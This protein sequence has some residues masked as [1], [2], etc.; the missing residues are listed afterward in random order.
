M[1]NGTA[2]LVAVNI[3][4]KEEA[5]GFMLVIAFKQSSVIVTVIACVLVAVTVTV[6]GVGT[7]KVVIVMCQL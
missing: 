6:I 1:E 7:N 5:T 3:G 4:A 2:G